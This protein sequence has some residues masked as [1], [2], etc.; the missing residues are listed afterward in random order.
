MSVTYEYNGKNGFKL[1]LDDS[2]EISL[3]STKAE[4]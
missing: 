2:L 3:I 1:T 4:K